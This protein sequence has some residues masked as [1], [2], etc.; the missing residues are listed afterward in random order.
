MDA[1]ML[2]AAKE[3]EMALRDLS[4]AM[5]SDKAM[6]KTIIVHPQLGSSFDEAKELSENWESKEVKQAFDNLKRSTG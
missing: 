2:K 6:Q 5:K 4:S 1:E 3:F